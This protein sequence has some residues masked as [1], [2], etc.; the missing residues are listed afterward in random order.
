MATVPATLDIPKEP[1]QRR[2]WVGYQLKIRGSSLRRIALD[3]GV[4]HQAVGQ[5]LMAPSFHLERVIAK[6]IGLSVQDLFPERYL[7]DGTRKLTTRGSQGNSGRPSR[8]GKGER[9]A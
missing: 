6:A 3:N 8:N 4:S 1:T 9:A 7:V 2:A 5:A